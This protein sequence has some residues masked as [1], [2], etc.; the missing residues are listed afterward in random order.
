LRRRTYLYI[1]NLYQPLISTNCAICHTPL[2][3]IFADIQN[4]R[5]IFAN[6]NGKIPFITVEREERDYFE[7]WNPSIHTE[8]GYDI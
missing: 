1:K 7:F 3:Y 2:Q 6:R 4:S 5:C 8:Y